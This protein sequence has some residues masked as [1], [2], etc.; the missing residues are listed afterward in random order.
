MIK[1]FLI[2]TWMHR[3]INRKM[4]L[5]RREGCEFSRFF[6]NWTKKKSCKSLQTHLQWTVF[7]SSFD[8]HYFMVSMLYCPNELILPAMTRWGDTLSHLLA[9]ES[10]RPQVMLMQMWKVTGLCSD[11]GLSVC[12]SRRFP[13][14]CRGRCVCASTWLCVLSRTAVAPSLPHSIHSIT[15]FLHL[16][17]Y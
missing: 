12:S 8:I 6:I 14:V 1:A 16:L 15:L 5:R 7:W 9:A 11:Q 2:C 4:A 13:G 10:C 17:P 3:M